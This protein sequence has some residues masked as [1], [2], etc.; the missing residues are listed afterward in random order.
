[1]NAMDL[2]TPEAFEANPSL[3]WQFYSHRRE[4][5]RKSQPNAGHFALAAAQAKL[6]KEGRQL[7]IITQNIDGLHQAAGA[8]NVLE[9]HGSLWRVKRVDHSGFAE[10]AGSVWEE[11]DIVV[12]SDDVPLDKLP[13]APDDGK[14]LRPAVVWFGEGLDPGV[15]GDVES[16]LAKVDMLLV[17]GTSSVVYP[18]AGLAPQVAARGCPVAEFNLETTGTTGVCK[19]AFQGKSGK[20]LPAALGVE[21]EV[22]DAMPAAGA[23]DGG[24]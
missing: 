19:F 23:A 15:M 7:S 11:R 22:A 8:S 2:A 24:S 21:Q 18:A 9:L 5:V 17:V 10:R 13:H 20:L 1:M 12:D 4:V 16:I 14:L 3:V 6:A